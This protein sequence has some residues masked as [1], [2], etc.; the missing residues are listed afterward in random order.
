MSR[1]C[2]PEVAGLLPTVREDLRTVLHRDP[3]VA[4]L[5]EA[6]L[7]PPLLAVWTHRLAHRL[8]ARGHR[9][10]ARLLSQ[11]GRL[12]TGVEIHPGARIGRRLFIDHG[13]GIVIGESAVIGD[14]VT[15]YH[16]VTL[17][18]VGWW[19]DNR[20]PPG[21]RRHPRVGHGVVLGTGST[22]LGPIDVGDAAVIGAHAL[23]TTDVPAGG[24]L[25]APAA[26][27]LLH[28]RAGRSLTKRSQS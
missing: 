8:F 14:D 1:P 7:H 12:L 5:R 2:G 28:P 16:Q 4:T 18:A 19:R 3:S 21:E 20:R 24:R 25:V 9:I 10:G 11:L 6:A 22:L 23:V 15:I 26:R 17:G 27:P 13:A